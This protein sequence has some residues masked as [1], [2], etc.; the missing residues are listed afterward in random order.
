MK[1]YHCILISLLKKSFTHFFL[2]LIS[3][4]TVC[5]GEN[6]STSYAPSIHI[7]RVRI[8]DKD[9][10]LK[11]I[12][13][14]DY[15]KN[16]LI[17]NFYSAAAD[18]EE[19]I[20]YKYQM[21]S[22]DNKWE[23]T[24][25]PIVQYTN[26]SP[27]DYTF[28]ASAI[29]E[30]GTWSIQPASVRFIIKPPFWQAWWFRLILFDIVIIGLMVME[31]IRFKKTVSEEKQK[32]EMER[33]IS[34]LELVALRSQMNPHFI[35]NSLNSIQRYITEN[36]KTSANKYLVDF[37]KLM[38]QTFENST[39]KTMPVSD[40][41]DSLKAYLHLEIMRL[42]ESKLEYEMEIDP[43]IDIFNEEIPPLILQPYVE[44]AIWHGISNVTSGKGKIKI[45]MI[46]ENGYLVCSVIDNGVG[47][48]KA[49]E[50]K[51]KD[52]THHKSGGMNVTK[53]RLDIFNSLYNNKKDIDIIDLFDE[54]KNPSGTEIK[55]YVSL[56]SD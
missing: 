16:K 50:L 8:G 44:N 15:S 45:K 7:T 51:D 19:N 6:T 56:D 24:K 12:Y 47:R 9:T 25:Y 29:N 37:S 22:I 53:E 3:Y 55:I 17:I 4:N 52:N 1:K 35:F 48:A 27:G 46:K 42:G 26:L 11:S 21:T 14:L 20:I 39:K 34:E 38:R 32:Y 54:N 10:S 5:A 43:S 18:S 13:E 31:H 33:K 49:S 28:T 23:E 30:K 2:I 41:I 40:T 36:D